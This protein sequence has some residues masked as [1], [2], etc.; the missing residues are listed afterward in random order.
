MMTPEAVKEFNDLFAGHVGVFV[1]AEGVTTFRTWDTEIKIKDGAVVGKTHNPGSR[2]T[3]PGWLDICAN[4]S[5]GELIPWSNAECDAVRLAI[6][7][8]RE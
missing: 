8:C 2:M 4:P 5:L 6:R 1:N 3:V 7:Q